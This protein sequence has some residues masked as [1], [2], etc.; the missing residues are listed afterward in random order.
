MA[1]EINIESLQSKL[2]EKL[3]PSGWGDKLKTFI[4]SDDFISIIKVLVK[5]VGEG[6]RFTPTLKQVF[7]AFEECPYDSLKVVVIGQDPYN[8]PFAA[9]GIAFSCSNLDKA[10]ASLRFIH[11]EIDRTV[12]KGGY[13]GPNDLKVWSNQGILLL[14]TALTTNIGK[15]G[16]HYALWQP[17]IAFVLDILN[18]QKPGLIYAFLGKKAQEWAESIPDNNFKLIASHPASAAYGNLD[19][20]D[21]D[22]L[23]NKISDLS[24]KHFK[25][26]IVW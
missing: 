11:K 16:T 15:A 4:G 26:K 12:Y 24:D 17:F 9:D 7:R 6:K 21:S 25:Q 13:T 5:E 22:D 8:Q 2:Y 19:N 18:F 10:E 14:N 1:Q 23:F 3:K 20:W